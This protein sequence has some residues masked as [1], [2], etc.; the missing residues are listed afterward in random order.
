M[1]SEGTYEILK[2]NEQLNTGILQCKVI[3][4]TLHTLTPR[5]HI[6]CKANSLYSL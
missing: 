4:H 5:L 2:F 3:E 1:A 6:A